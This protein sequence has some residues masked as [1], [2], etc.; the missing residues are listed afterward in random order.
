MVGIS[1]GLQAPQAPPS[2]SNGGHTGSG[3][4]Y[5]IGPRTV[6]FVPATQRVISCLATGEES[7]KT[8]QVEALGTQEEASMA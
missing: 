2:L 6:R 7:S 4:R 8:T 3:S 5:L 1:F